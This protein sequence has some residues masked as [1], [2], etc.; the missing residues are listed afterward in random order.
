VPEHLSVVR[1]GPCGRQQLVALFDDAVEWLVARGQTGQWGSQPF[2]Q[3]PKQMA[4]IE[5]WA[6]EELW[7]AA[8]GGDR[9]ADPAGAILLGTHMDYV[10]PPD[11]PELYVKVLLT[12]SE[13]RGRGVG[14]LLID[15]AIDQARY[16]GAEQLRVDCYAGVPEL[17]AQYEHLGFTL[18]DRYLL[19]QFNDWPIAVLAMAL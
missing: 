10:E 12:A 16:R 1:A 6:R 8:P 14:Q 5:Q 4:R 18:V 19:K 17:P 7:L 11:R 2:S 15:H 13:W 3:Q 9:E